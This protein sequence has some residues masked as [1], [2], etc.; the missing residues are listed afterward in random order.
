[1]KKW[2]RRGDGKKEGSGDVGVELN[3]SR[4]RCENSPSNPSV[5]TRS[6]S[7][8]SGGSWQPHCIVRR[9]VC[10]KL[11]S[12]EQGCAVA[13]PV[14]VFGR[15]LQLIASS[16][17]RRLK[18][19][20]E[21]GEEQGGAPAEDCGTVVAVAVGSGSVARVTRLKKWPSLGEQSVYLLLRLNPALASQ[22]Q[23]ILFSAF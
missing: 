13:Q 17:Q 21:G 12:I 11:W 22:Q 2:R 16:Q 19:P 10:Q 7:S 4:W 18:N 5:R 15:Q 20:W 1:M 8:I 6:S 14:F 9:G 3:R 23:L